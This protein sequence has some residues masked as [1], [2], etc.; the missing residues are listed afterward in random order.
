[1]ITK[2]TLAILLR[3]T[4]LSLN[5][6]SV[7]GIGCTTYCKELIL[8]KIFTNYKRKSAFYRPCTFRLPF[9]KRNMQPYWTVVRIGHCRYNR[10]EPKFLCRY[11]GKDEIDND[12]SDTSDSTTECTLFRDCYRRIC[13]SISIPLDRFGFTRCAFFS[14]E[15]WLLQIKKIK[16]KKKVRFKICVANHNSAIRTNNNIW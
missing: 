4:Y 12:S 16:N 10:N 15:R 9:I 11:V 1:M 6:S 7:P 14:T 3:K 13:L 5:C 2:I 8:Q